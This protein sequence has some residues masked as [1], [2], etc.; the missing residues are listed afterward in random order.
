LSSLQNAHSG[1][2][3]APA[4]QTAEY[5]KETKKFMTAKL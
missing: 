3:P 4:G 5:R 2:A 1:S